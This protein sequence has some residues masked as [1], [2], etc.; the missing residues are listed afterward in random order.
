[1]SKGLQIAIAVLT[2]C[3]GLVWVIASGGAGE[4][5]FR[6]SGNV[7]EY[8]AADRPDVSDLRIH[9]FVVDGS[10]QKDL[11]AGH[12]DF[13][14]ADAGDPRALPVR[15]QG[16]DM[17][18]LFGDGAEVVIEGSIHQGVFLAERVMAKC[19]SKYEATTEA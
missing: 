9:G 17:P 19:P 6:Y 16:I 5:T 2:V 8:L 11:P 18:D 7:D 1:M 4:G 13:E 3:G 14:I 12:V 15:Y 10:I